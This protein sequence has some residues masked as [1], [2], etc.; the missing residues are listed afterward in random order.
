MNVE[1][2]AMLDE[3][4]EQG[5]GQNSVAALLLVP[6][7]FNRASC[8]QSLGSATEMLSGKCS[9]EN[10]PCRSGVWFFFLTRK[11]DVSVS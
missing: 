8:E 5:I 7:S 10:A 11:Q 4:I 1:D 2:K 3:F 6:L 9:Q